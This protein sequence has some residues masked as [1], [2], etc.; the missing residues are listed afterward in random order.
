MR[1]AVWY[2]CMN[3]W[4]R[5]L[6]ISDHSDPLAA[7]GG[8]EAGGQNV[9]VDELSSHLAQMGHTVHVITRHND[10]SR[11]P[12]EQSPTGY[13]V[14]RV[15]VGKSG[16]ISKEEFALHLPEFIQEVSAHIGANSYDIIHSHYW[17]SGMAGCAVRQTHH[18][19]LV[20]TFHSLGKIKHEELLGIDPHQRKLREDAEMQIVQQTDCLL[21]ESNDERRALLRLYNAESDRI[22]IVPAGVD[23]DHFC[24]GNKIAARKE[25]R[26][27]EKKVILYVGRFV[28]QKG[29]PPL[30]QA[31]AQLRRDGT[32]AERV[33]TVLLLIGGDFKEPTNK[34]SRVHKRIQSMIIS[35]D[36]SSSVRVLGQVPNAGLPVYYRA[37][38]LCVVPS[39]YEPFG[40]VPLEAMAC[41]TPVVASHVGGMKS[42]VRHLHTGLHARSNKSA[43]F[44]FKMEIILRNPALREEFG[45][46]ARQ[47]VEQE[48]SWDSVSERVLA[49]YNATIHHA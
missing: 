38:D 22:T 24:P 29:L 6:M 27:K 20:H 30:L 13:T 42:T 7:L 23:I 19:P 10:P 32:D 28:A 44:K 47:R 2:T 4:K 40:I 15:P 39:R 14:F 21:A 17:L 25:L 16:F 26:I 1:R 12:V 33:E 3:G 18:L 48:F 5:I 37:A 43:D 35:L 8:E 45:R 31:Y 11:L 46:Q 9:Y 36:L 34:Q 49:C 41:G